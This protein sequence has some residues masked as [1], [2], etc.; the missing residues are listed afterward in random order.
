MPAE[1]IGLGESIEATVVK[2]ASDFS[3]LPIILLI[4]FIFFGF[5]CYKAWKEKNN[6][7]TIRRNKIL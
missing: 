5:L 1:S 4:S 6:I 2:A 3:L 7:N